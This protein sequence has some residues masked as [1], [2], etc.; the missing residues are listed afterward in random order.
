MGVGK[1]VGSEGLAREGRGTL[2]SSCCAF[3][4][5]VQTRGN[6]SI[7]VCPQKLLE[8]A[9]QTAPQQEP[10]LTKGHLF[11]TMLLLQGYFNLKLNRNIEA[12]LVKKPQWTKSMTKDL[13]K[14]FFFC[15]FA[16]S[17]NF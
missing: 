14:I 15:L 16:S 4:H 8:E 11:L 1:D 13:R 6:A 9:S 7:P 2:L 10:S 3:F 17:K 5:P 12:V